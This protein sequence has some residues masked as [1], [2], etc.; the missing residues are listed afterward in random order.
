[1]RLPNIVYFKNKLLGIKRG[2]HLIVTASGNTIL[3]YAS[4]SANFAA[5]FGQP[6]AAAS[7]K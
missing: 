6:F 1:M 3:Y 2:C 5:A 4:Y 7:S